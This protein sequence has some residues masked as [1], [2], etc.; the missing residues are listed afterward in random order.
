MNTYKKLLKIKNPVLILVSVDLKRN[1]NR[2][3]ILYPNGRCEYVIDMLADAEFRKSCF[4]KASLKDT[5]EAMKKFDK[6]TLSI[7]KFVEIK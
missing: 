1:P 5:V 4:Q 2:Y 7:E 3:R 6:Y